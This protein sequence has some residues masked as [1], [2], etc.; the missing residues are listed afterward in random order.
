MID[1][2]LLFAI[3]SD[4]SRSATRP[5]FQISSGHSPTWRKTTRLLR[6]KGRGA[7]SVCVTAPIILPRPTNPWALHLPSLLPRGTTRASAW[8]RVA[9]CH[10]SALPVP[11]ARRVGLAGSA[12]WPCVPRRIRAGPARHVSLRRHV[13]VHATST[14]RGLWNK[15]P[16]FRDFR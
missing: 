1:E 4:A 15:N 6:I 16:L 9:S 14:P 11:P 3:A 10:V 5:A 8:T 7:V 2:S 12:T 13:S